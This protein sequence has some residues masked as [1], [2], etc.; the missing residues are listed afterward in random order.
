GIRDFHVNGVQTCALPICIELPLDQLPAPGG[1]G[2]RTAAGV[3]VAE[4]S[5]PVDAVPAPAGAVE[6]LRELVRRWRSLRAPRPSGTRAPGGGRHMS[7]AWPEP[8]GVAQG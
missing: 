8:E 1:T 2:P 3:T 5:E 4:A 7:D 6:V